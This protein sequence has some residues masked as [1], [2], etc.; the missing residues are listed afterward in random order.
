M[1]LP[2]TEAVVDTAVPATEAAVDTAVPVSDAAVDTVVVATDITEHAEQETLSASAKT[3]FFIGASLALRAKWGY[4]AW[5]FAATFATISL[6]ATPP[7]S[8]PAA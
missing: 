4:R 3:R 5:C 2:A 8:A 7:L 6:N 1:A